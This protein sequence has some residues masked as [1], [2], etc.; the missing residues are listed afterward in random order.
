MAFGEGK[1]RRQT[2]VGKGGEGTGDA[3]C[4]SQCAHWLRNDTV[5]KRCSARLGGGVRAA[6]P[7]EGYKG[8]DGRATARVAPTKCCEEC[9][10]WASA[11]TEVF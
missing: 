8:C 10:S 2:T 9:V 6:R 4:H 3:D 5:S 7:T 11:P 1:N